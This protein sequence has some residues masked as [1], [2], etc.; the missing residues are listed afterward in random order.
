[1]KNTKQYW[2][3]VNLFPLVLH[4][5]AGNS[6][7]P[8]HTFVMTRN[9]RIFDRL[10]YLNWFEGLCNADMQVVAYCYKMEYK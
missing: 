7:I 4:R 6:K 1:M 8:P 2:R 3:T 5:E 10:P 9:G